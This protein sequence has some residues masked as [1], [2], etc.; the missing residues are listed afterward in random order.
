MNVART[1]ITSFGAIEPIH[2]EPEPAIIM[3]DST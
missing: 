3:T 2:S 1:Y